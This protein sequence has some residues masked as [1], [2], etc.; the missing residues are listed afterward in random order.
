MIKM[1][2]KSTLY[3]LLV[4]LTAFISFEDFLLKFLPVSDSIFFYSRFISEILIYIAFTLVLAIK[5]IKRIPLVRTPI[6]LPIFLF[7]GSAFLSILINDS[8]IWGS[9]ANLRPWLRFFILFYLILN[10][11]ITTIQASIINR[12]VI[13]AGIVQVAIGLIQYISHG[14][15][16]NFLLPRAS[17]TEIGGIAK[18][19]IILKAG[20]E[21]GS[22]YGAAGD[23][24][25][26]GTFIILILILVISKL[27][28]AKLISYGENNENINSLNEDKILSPKFLGFLL[29]FLLI[30]ISLSYVRACVFAAIVLI[31]IH[32]LKTFG[33]AR[34]AIALLV[35]III[36]SLFFIATPPEYSGNARIE[37]QSIL[38]N[39]TGILTSDYTK[40]LKNQRLGALIGTAPTVI[41]NRPF[42]GYGADQ[43]SA[44]DSLNASKI[45]FLTKVWTTEGFKD[46]YWVAI[47][48][49]YGLAG[50]ISLVW[51]FWRLYYSAQNIYKF[52]SEQITKEISLSVK[53]I[54][55]ITS[56]LLFFNRTIEFRIYGFYFWL[57]PGLMFRLYIQE[58]TQVWE[59]RKE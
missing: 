47:L 15:L 54:I 10:I 17:D 20:R 49:F 30:A 59:L 32:S 44:I 29:P 46:V 25:M 48:T 45:S 34:T 58:R 3:L 7:L 8:P 2:F 5:I 36:G 16:D 43:V 28:I 38:T 52:S 22:I 19:N 9:I 27:H 6:D 50:L 57:L 13:L 4:I 21:I 40:Q 56:F 31:I 11:K 55:I 53:Y 12:T 41:F 42:L 33:R 39:L 24:V 51:M 18:N 1:F 35:V 37:E 23:T 26:Y 14:V